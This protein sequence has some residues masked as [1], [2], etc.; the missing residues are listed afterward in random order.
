MTDTPA[1]P[2]LIVHTPDH[3]AAAFAA[4]AATGRAVTVQSA[5]GAAAYLGAGVFA[6]MIEP[7]AAAHPG[8]DVRVVLDCG[9]D[10]GAALN[11][12]RLGARAIRLQAE[13]ETLGKVRDLA[14]KSGATLEEGDGDGL[15]LLGE[16]DPHAAAL[17]WVETAG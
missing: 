7:A 8:A 10:V 1:R 12:L 4:A 11:A 15:N 9:D 3:A 14:R 5:E 6:A 17:A 13:G 2:V 16:M